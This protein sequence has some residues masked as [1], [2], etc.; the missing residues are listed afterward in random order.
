M[1]KGH[2]TTPHKGDPDDSD[3]L[4][5]R[6]A[7][8]TSEPQLTAAHD[9]ARYFQTLL[10]QPNADDPNTRSLFAH[11]L[12][13]EWPYANTPIRFTGVA[14]TGE[15][16]GG[17]GIPS[18]Y[19]DEEVISR[20]FGFY[21]LIDEDSGVSRPTVGHYVAMERA[22]QK[23]RIPAF[24]ALDDIDE[25]ILPAPSPEARAQR[26]A[27]YHEDQAK[28]IDELVAASSR[29]DQII[30]SL[31]A[32]S[33]DVDPTKESEFDHL[34]DAEEYIRRRA[35]IEPHANYYISVLGDLIFIDH[36]GT[37]IPRRLKKILTLPMSV[38]DIT[39]RPANA[40]SLAN[41]TSRRCAPFIDVIA[42]YDHGDDA[43]LLIPCTSIALIHSVRYNGAP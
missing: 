4:L 40:G 12:D 21:D 32:F 28:W 1:T 43:H 5:D 23:S 29:N 7:K 35:K 15:G 41:G 10:R 27:Y 6:L 42:F 22:S 38:K 13:A 26:F 37:T 14:W 39:L 11:Q 36:R 34:M 30:S 19:I 25:F 20:G 2:E 8:N 3:T 33:M 16:E 17:K 18:T 9:R 31:R 24:I